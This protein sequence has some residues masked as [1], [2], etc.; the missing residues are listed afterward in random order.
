MF[1]KTAGRTGQIELVQGNIRDEASSRAALAG[2]SAIINAV[3]ILY[4]SG[5]QKFDAVQS[6]GAARLALMR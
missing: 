3:G 4:E 5:P 6:A 2:A 1:L